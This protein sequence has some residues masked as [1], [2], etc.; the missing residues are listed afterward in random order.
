MPITYAFVPVA[1]AGVAGWIFRRQ[2]V[3]SIRGVPA[4]ANTFWRPQRLGAPRRT[5]AIVLLCCAALIGV[6]AAEYLTETTYVA[7]AAAIPVVIAAWLLTA[8]PAAAVMAFGCLLALVLYFTGSLDALSSAVELAGLTIVGSL[9][10]LAA[11]LSHARS[12][13]RELKGDLEEHDRRLRSL[14]KITSELINSFAHEM[15]TPLGVA[16]GY[17]SLLEDGDIDVSEHRV[18]A[19]IISKKLEEISDLTERSLAEYAQK[20]VAAA[21]RPVLS[22]EAR[23]VDLET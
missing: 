1:L 17:V 9:I 15:R 10:I 8:R 4:R 16:R 3:R 21:R 14:E 7:I 18:V 23:S 12:E 22:P 6:F 19:S 13:G 5:V 20:T 11:N 2:L